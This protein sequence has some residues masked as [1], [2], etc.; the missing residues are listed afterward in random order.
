M[1]LEGK[2]RREVKIRGRI[3]SKTERRQEK[4]VEKNFEKLSYIK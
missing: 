4:S 3:G 1:V 2:E